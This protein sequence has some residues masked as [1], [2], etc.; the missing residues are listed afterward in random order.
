MN[1]TDP[2]WWAPHTDDY[3]ATYDETPRP[4]GPDDA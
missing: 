2:D 1:A 3:T 4:T